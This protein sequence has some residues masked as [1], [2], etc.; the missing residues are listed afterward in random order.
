[1]TDDTL[2][3]AIRRDERPLDIAPHEALDFL[4]D[5]LRGLRR[6]AEAGAVREDVRDDLRA[7]H[8]KILGLIRN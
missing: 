4:E 5:M 7:V 2:D 8:D 1:M 6:V 3:R